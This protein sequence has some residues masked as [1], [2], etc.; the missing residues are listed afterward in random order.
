MLKK[1]FIVVACIAALS[2]GMAVN[3]A[4]RVDFTTL[5]GEG[6]RWKDLQGKWVVVN[7]FAEWCA[8][9]LREI[10]ELNQFYRENRDKLAMFAVSFDPLSHKQLVD[11]QDQYDIQFPVIASIAAPMPM[12]SPKNLPVTFLIHPDG[13]VAKQLFGEQSAASL[14][15]SLGRL[16][17]L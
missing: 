17:G 15:A 13:S 5:E 9:C 8:P 6:H 14:S 7:Y 12:A 10:P 4:N 11:L 1:L 16:Q 2:L 3:L